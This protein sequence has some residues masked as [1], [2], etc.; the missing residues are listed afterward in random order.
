MSTKELSM[1]SFLFDLMRKQNTHLSGLASELGVS[2]ATV[3]RWL[4]GHDT[5]NMYSCRRIAEYSDLPLK[6]VLAIAGHL[7][8]VP[9]RAPAEWPEFRE[10]ALNKYPEE[11]DE[12]LVATIENLI[13][14]RRQKSRVATR[15][16]SA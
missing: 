9:E 14:W 10:Y 1:R 6:K 12:D 2:H 3:G 4:S 5:P 7:P 15:T 11:L 16:K 8:K 13:E